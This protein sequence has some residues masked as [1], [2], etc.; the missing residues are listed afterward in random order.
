V[1]E[2]HSSST[3]AND[4]D[5]ARKVEVVDY[6][7][8]W[9]RLFEQ[10][11]ARIRAAVGNAAVGVEHVGSTSVPGLAAKPV[12]DIHLT[13]VDSADEAAYLPQLEAA[14]Y[15]LLV[16]EPGWFE[17]RMFKGREPEVNLHV[18]SSGCSELDRMRLFRDWLRRSPEDV[19]LYAATKRALAE[20]EWPQVQ[21]YAD[22]KTA[23]VSE[24]MARAQAWAAE[25][26]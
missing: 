21:D 13:V 10:E 23:V 5:R 7:P 9:P 1:S 22:A 19:A 17:H 24:I 11:S 8:E 20:R 15:R 4:P 3:P 26:D 12:I 25:R 16:R 14:G 6:D 18:F 2:Q